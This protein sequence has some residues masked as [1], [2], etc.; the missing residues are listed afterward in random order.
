[1][2]YAL[3]CHLP[4]LALNIPAHSTS[5]PL[6]V[7]LDGT[8]LKTDMLHES[9][10]LLIKRNPL[11][12]FMLPLWLLRGKAYLKMQIAARVEFDPSCLP[13]RAE[14]IAHLC[15]E[16]AAGRHV[17]LTT[18]ADNK[19]ARQIAG[20]LKLFDEV[21]ASDGER[22]LSGRQK[23][24][25]LVERYGERRFIYAGNAPI[26]LD[27]W[28]HA[29]A[30]IVV[31]D[32]DLARRT[33]ELTHV[34]RVLPPEPY[35]PASLLQSVRLH[36]WLKN[37]LIFVPLLTAH[38]FADAALLVQ[39][40][41]AFFS[42]GLCASA[43]YLLNDL[44]DLEADRRHPTKR[45]RP[46]AA[47]ALPIWFGVILIP[48]F[49]FSSAAIA[50]VLPDSFQLAL[51]AYLLATTAYSF[52]LKRFA[53]IDVLALAGL[54]TLR[55]IAGGAAVGI[56]PTQWLLAFSMFL[57]LSLALVKRFSE[58]YETRESNHEAASGR[59]YYAS[60]LEQIASLGGASGYMSVLVLALYINSHD[61]VALYSHP[62]LL[63]LVCAV[64]L[65]WISRVWLLAHRGKM[66]EDPIVFAIRDRASHLTLALAA[67]I[68]ALAA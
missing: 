2:P 45:G 13:Y 39:A 15:E 33:G 54:Y 41:L 34:Q 4:Y 3:P 9:L 6:C 20:H 57:F 18:A 48:L 53:L 17:V 61:V 60:D 40:L 52:F 14:L 32:A 16:R 10:I 65:Y 66:H 27:I 51:L 58:L 46:F 21:L 24:A 31:G 47:G 44:L 43:V 62:N 38:K 36:Q 28:R 1:M 50:R 29:A 12:V 59:G 26:D 7:D 42:F 68:L 23:L 8:L 63:W 49:L 35:A 67:A 22:N 64:L 37:L 5:F 56:T 30:A 25:L 55:I 19:I 11:Y